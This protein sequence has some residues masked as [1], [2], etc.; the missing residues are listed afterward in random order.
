MIDSVPADMIK[1]V[2]KPNDA[3]NSAYAIV[4]GGY[5]THTYAIASGYLRIKEGVGPRIV[6]VRSR[7]L[8]GYI[9]AGLESH[10]SLEHAV[11]NSVLQQIYSISRLPESEQD[12]AAT[13]L[14]AS[15]Q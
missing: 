12:A 11:K 13:L 10:D 3:P 14:L 2:V 9:R 1:I 8:V 15:L 7:A 4:Y 6:T 5:G